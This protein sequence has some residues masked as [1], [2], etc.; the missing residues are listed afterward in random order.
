MHGRLARVFA[1]VRRS[2]AGRLTASRRT[3]T[4][5]WRWLDHAAT[6]RA[7]W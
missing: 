7:D 3:A 1:S 6:R 4:L 2:T 5:R